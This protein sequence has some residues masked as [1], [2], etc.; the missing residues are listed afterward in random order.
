MK[1]KLSLERNVIDILERF[2]TTFKY[3]STPPPPPP[4]PAFTFFPLKKNCFDPRGGSL[5]PLNM[6]GPP[7]PPPNLPDYNCLPVNTSIIRDGENVSIYL[8]CVFV[9]ICD[10][11]NCW[12]YYKVS[13]GHKQYEK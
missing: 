7:P 12:I 6:G 4:P 2:L 9:D 13:L 5:P 11:I 8:I 1:V 10:A 3:G